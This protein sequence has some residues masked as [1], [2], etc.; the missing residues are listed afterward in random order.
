V[1]Q[2]SDVENELKFEAQNPMTESIESVIKKLFDAGRSRYSQYVY[3][4]QETNDCM[5]WGT[6]N[7]VDLTIAYQSYKRAVETELYR[8]AK[9]WVYGVGKSMNNQHS[10]SGM[11][12]PLAMQW[13]SKNGVLPEDVE[14][15]PKYSGSLQKQLLGASAGRDFY[16]KW[17]SV[18]VEY[19]V[20]VVPL[21][22]NVEAW[23]LWAMTGRFIAYGTN[24]RI[25]L[26]NGVWRANGSWAHAMCAGAPWYPD[27]AIT[28]INSH[29]D[30]QGKLPKDVLGQIISGGRGYGSA[31]GIWKFRR[32]GLNSVD[33]STLGRH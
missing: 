8:T 31:F 3:G 29:G 32:R 18:A 13:I 11:S 24:L 9:Y 28:N 2:W 21:P 27:G 12:V 33:Y 4:R 20:D 25:S 7:M 6:S 30:G 14:G 17:K 19:D 16:N 22:M 1:L 10:D 5:S 23:Q 15:L 26:Q